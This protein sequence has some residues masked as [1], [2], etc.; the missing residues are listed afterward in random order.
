MSLEQWGALAA[1][2]TFLGAI[3]TGGIHFG[4]KIRR[5]HLIE[6]FLERAYNDF[7]SKAFPPAA[8]SYSHRF[9]PQIASELHMTSEQAYS[10]A[11]GSKKLV[12]GN[13]G[14]ADGKFWFSFKPK[15]GTQHR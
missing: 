15:E 4:Q 5:R 6:K 9:V 2:F 3:V 10:A 13:T 7:D 14:G 12:C 1:I 8:D 11:I